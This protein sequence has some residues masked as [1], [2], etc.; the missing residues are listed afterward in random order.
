VKSLV[1][2]FANRMTGCTES[3]ANRFS[4]VLSSRKEHR[5][6]TPYQ[7][8]L[9]VHLFSEVMLL[10]P[11]FMHLSRERCQK[12]WADMENLSEKARN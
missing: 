9:R 3:T 5:S 11:Q 10:A 4:G 1:A 6:M 12:E 8:P 7:R 2:I